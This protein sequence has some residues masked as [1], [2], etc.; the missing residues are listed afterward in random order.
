MLA[1]I[2]F[3]LAYSP[4]SAAMGVSSKTLT[5]DVVAVDGLA[6][7][8]YE[9]AKRIEVYYP[10][11]YE[12]LEM[13][14]DKTAQD[15]LRQYAV[16]ASLE[17]KLN[18]F[19]RLYSS[20][21]NAHH[22]P[23][24]VRGIG[25]PTGPRL[26]LPFEVFGQGLRFSQAFFYVSS[27]T[28]HGDGV[29]TA[30]GDRILAYDGLPIDE[31]VRKAR[32]EN[33]SESP[34]DHIGRIADHMTHQRH[35]WWGKLRCWKEGDT[36][37]LELQD[38]A[39]GR[40]KEARFSWA[41]QKVSASSAAIA[42]PV[43]PPNV[44]GWSFES[45]RGAYAPDYDSL[46][47]GQFGFLGRLSKD[48]RKWLL[49]KIFQFADLTLVQKAITE[50]RRPGYEGVILDFAQN[51]GGD[52]SAMTLLGG[53]LGGTFNLELS[54]IRI[55]REFRDIEMLKE[56]T[57]GDTKANLFFPLVKDE[58]LGKMTPFT[59][60]GCIDDS[61]PLKTEFSNYFDR[62]E[63]PVIVSSEPVKR[64][65]LIT[66][67]GTASKTDSIAALF[68]ATKFGP[69]IGTPAMGSS[70]TY[71]FRKE[72]VV[73]VAEHNALLVGV[74]FTPDLSLASDC[75]EVQGNPPAPDVLIER[76]FANRAY[77][78]TLTWIS[79]A[80][81]LEKWVSPPNLGVSCPLGEAQSALKKFGLSQIGTK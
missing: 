70:G 30:V 33:S 42:S 21:N 18:I 14:W 81:A 3:S 74:T 12:R 59:P 54:A 2:L 76:T 24:T 40:R 77:Y 25:S 13:D 44:A 4:A 56:S 72:Y 22:R 19:A 75:A 1:L 34:E 61:C 20:W 62:Y 27:V 6:R 17:D 50:A 53:L 52:D 43:F 45:I 49:I 7:Q 37:E 8:Y 73:P 57:F 78:D 68:R 23:M 9:D 67:V 60:F 69:I 79:A 71:Y 48:G 46:P 38:A 28:A 10:K 29:P 58:N 80:S 26:V 39:T 64:I 66:G 15:Y 11:Q 51:G 55:V 65:A 63:R 41:A 47:D 36:V 16:A 31:Y 35:C 5:V 32:D